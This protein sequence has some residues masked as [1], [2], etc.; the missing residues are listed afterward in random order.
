D[1]PSV[2][3]MPG[4]PAPI[5]KS[6]AKK[7]TEKAPEPAPEPEP[8]PPAEAPPAEA[9]P[10]EAAPPAAPA[11]D[12]PSAE[13]GAPAAAP[14]AEDGAA[15][16][17]ADAPSADA[18]AADAPAEAAPAETAVVEEPP[19]AP[20]PPPPAG[21]TNTMRL[22]WLL[23]PLISLFMPPPINLHSLVPTSAPLD[24]TVEDVNDCSLLTIEWK[25]P[26]TI[27][28][29]G[30]D[31]YTV[32]YCKDGT[33]DWVEANEELTPANRFCIKNLTTGD[34]LHVRVVAVNPGGRSEPGALAEPVPI[35]EIVDRPKI[36]LPRFLR[37]RFVKQVGEQIN[38]VVPFL[39][40]PKPVVSWLKD[41]QP[42]DTK[43]VNIR[44]SDKDSIMF[45]RA[46]Q[47]EDSGVYEM[48]VKVDCFEDKAT[49][50]LQIW[51]VSTELPGPPASVKLVDTWGF[52]AALEW[53]PPKNNGNTDITGYTVQKADRKT[54]EW[55]T[56]LEHYHRLTA[57]VSDLIMGNSYSF[58]VFAE[59]QVGVSETCAI[60]KEVA[61]IQKTGI[62]YK[63]PEYPEHDFSEAPKFTTP[64][65]DHAATVGYTT[66]LLCSVRGS[67]KP[68]I[69]WLKNQMVIGDDPKFR[70]LSNQGICSLEI[71]KPCSFDGGVY[72]CR[73]K[74]AQ[75]EATVSCKLEVKH[76]AAV[77]AAKEADDV[78]ALIRQ[79]TPTVPAPIVTPTVYVPPK[80]SL[81]L[82]TKWLD[83]FENE[84]VEFKCAVDGSDWTF[85]WER[86]GE[87]VQ[88]SD[89]KVSLSKEGSLLKITAAAKTYAG[90]YSCK[91]QHKTKGVTTEASNS[92][93]LKVNDKPK[94]TVTRSSHFDK[95][96]PGESI[97][98]TC[99]VAVS[100]GWE[101]LWYH[102]KNETQASSIDTFE[103]VSIDHHKSG[104]YHCKAKRGLFLTAESETTTL[105]VSDPP[106]PAQ[107]LR[108]R[109][110]DVFKDETVELSCEVD[111]SDWT[112]TWYKNQVKI[113][114]DSILAVSSNP[115]GEGL[116]KITSVSR[117]HQG[118]YACKAE[119]KARGVTSGFSNTIDIKVYDNVPTPTLR[120]EPG[121]NQMYEGETVNF[122]CKVDVST[123]W[124]YLW[125]KDGEIHPGSISETFSIRLALSNKGN[126]SCKAT[127]GKKTLTDFSEEIHQNVLEI[128]FPYLNNVTEW[129]DVF[130]TESVKLS[131]GMMDG[132][133]D[134]TYTWYK[135]GQQV[136]AVEAAS[137]DPDKT[138]L[139]IN[140]TSKNHEGKY[141][142]KGHLKGR[143][144]SS[145]L[146]LD[147]FLSV[148]EKKPSV[149][150]TQNPDYKVMFPGE[151]V[152][153]SCHISESS[154]WMYSWYKDNKDLGVSEDMLKVSSVGTANSGTYTC[155]AKRGTV[156][157]FRAGSS[158]G[159]GLEV[160]GNKPKPSITRQ[161]S[162]DKVY[163]GESVSFKCNVELSSGW[164]YLWFKNK[165]LL[166]ISGSNFTIRDANLSHSGIYECVARREKTKYTTEHSDESN[167]HIYEIPVPSVEN[168][169]QWL[170]VFPTESMKLTCRMNGSSDW[171]YTWY[172]DGQQVQAVEAV[173]FDSHRTN[174]SINSASPSHRGLYKCS[175]K[176]KNRSVSSTNSSELRLYVYDEKPTV[177][178]MQNPEH[179]VMHTGDAV[180]L[181]CH[182][183]VSSGW[184]Y[185]WFKGSSQLPE[186][187]SNHTITNVETKDSGSY[188][189]QT[190]RKSEAFHS[191]LSEAV[192][193]KIEERPQAGIVL[194]TGWSEAFSTDSL[195]LE[196]EVKESKDSWNFTW[197][198][199]EQPINQLPS[200]TYTVTPQNDPEQ[201]WY[202]CQGIRNE[203]PSYSKRSESFKTKNLLLKRRVLL[204]ISGCIVFGIAAVFI[205]CIALR[206]M[207]KPADDEDKQEESNL[208]LTMAQLKD[209][210]DAPSLLVEYITD[211]ALNAAPKEEEENGTICSETTPLPITTEEDQGCKALVLLLN[212]RFPNVLEVRRLH[213]SQFAAGVRQSPEALY[214]LRLFPLKETGAEYA[215]TDL[216]A[217]LEDVGQL[218]CARRTGTG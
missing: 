87:R 179:D 49:I 70:Q 63:P 84:I 164:E 11:E 178:L 196:C 154:G 46:S 155:L 48:T 73:A 111:S 6:P 168:I 17:A 110:L 189:C 180:S 25:A 105:Q 117:I 43:R 176:L 50:T 192:T 207:R 213:H 159:L 79:V 148:Y 193:L 191:D 54:G 200:Q 69:E 186:T 72:T 210:S 174:F 140:S 66:K 7:A 181:S 5:K 32:E 89:P 81:T 103:I 135:D 35:R 98:F 78:T 158:Q 24:V 123:G 108:T 75:G 67:P 211:A 122:I 76:L 90:S 21:N 121:F 205:G 29:S 201:G 106:K 39:G 62:V 109:W 65:I 126:Y 10:A 28:D 146:S 3:T 150:L 91:G 92:L 149:T 116:L 36:R 217:L 13:G 183:N 184:K 55:F 52:N 2:S 68:K 139:S 119:L 9:P 20:T 74:N 172:K 18:P 141:E 59:N 22:F 208:F 166:N 138:T 34:L 202:T 47:R 31:G 133:S 125:Y 124:Q 175:A 102:N 112:V 4:K 134:W 85:I 137:F 82:V 38:L 58:R 160:K 157:V 170:D 171:T 199:G 80:P 104:Q 118:Q 77:C 130:P 41:G 218:G 132:S 53:T 93:E 194:I 97:S 163:V 60:T 101:Y 169:T 190:Q 88:E 114:E 12:A 51:C 185:L 30:L 86:S 14:A 61:T 99:K 214:Y 215:E 197:F 144:V 56:V 120:K 57:T 42:L 19:K 37:S 127:R 95:M 198:K 165:A 145:I 209:R 23:S 94:P 156:Q 143:H 1:W 142:C 45:I 187:E 177:K 161:P 151:S 182:V 195:L 167:L 203:R 27:G 15:A 40:K 129:L 8:A 71:R 113:Q 216:F 107:E 162:A 83:V 16:P 33:T 128:P 44:N 212:I 64:L 136:Q 96:F 115:D 204:S 147:L 26:E 152:D 131:C 153:F 206:V 100:S 173:S 188:Q